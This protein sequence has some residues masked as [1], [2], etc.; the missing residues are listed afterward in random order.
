MS[1]EWKFDW[2]LIQNWIKI[3]NW[4]KFYLSAKTADN[5]QVSHG[6]FKSYHILSSTRWIL[7]T[8]L[9]DVTHLFADI[10]LLRYHQ[11]IERW[12]PPPYSYLFDFGILHLWNAQNFKSTL[13]PIPSPLLPPPPLPQKV[14]FL[15]LYFYSIAAYCNKLRQT[16]P[17]NVPRNVHPP[18]PKI[19]CCFDWINYI[20]IVCK[21]CL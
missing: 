16:P 12:A 14:E 17:K 18:S 4:Y 8:M 19:Q 1:S 6:A 15:I 9:R 2:K 21:F 10:Q 3:W 11:T 13:S 7:W 20:E 5:P